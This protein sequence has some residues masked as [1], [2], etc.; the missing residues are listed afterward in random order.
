M[1]IGY[2][3]FNVVY[4]NIKANLNRIKEMITVADADLIVLPELFF[5]MKGENNEDNNFVK[6][7]DCSFDT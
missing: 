4:K 6:H 2:C 3:Q 7:A 1:N 5:S